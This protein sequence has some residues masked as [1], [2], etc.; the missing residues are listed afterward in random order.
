M[1]FDE[2]MMKSVEILFLLAIA[3]LLIGLVSLGVAAIHD[4]I[5]AEKEFK[6]EFL[7]LDDVQYM[8]EGEIL[9]RFG[10][11]VIKDHMRNKIICPLCNSNEAEAIEI[12]YAFKLLL[13]ELQSM[14]IM[15][16]FELKNKYE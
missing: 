3:G 12:S 11:M 13:E 7:I 16:K 2:I 10:N 5:Y 15:T 9:Y 14:H 8:D 4:T 1:D 6:S